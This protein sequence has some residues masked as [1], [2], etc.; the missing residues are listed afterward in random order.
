MTNERPLYRKDGEAYTQA[1]AEAKAEFDLW[2]TSGRERLLKYPL[3]GT[4]DYEAFEMD[5]I[6]GV[7]IEV[8][9]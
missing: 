4:T 5:A 3:F 9:V 7:D 8:T 1:L 2:D 6:E